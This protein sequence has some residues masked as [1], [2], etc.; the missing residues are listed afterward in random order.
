MS[1]HAP[2]GYQIPDE[3]VRVAEAAF[4]KGNMYMELH[5]K[6]GMLYTNTQFAHLFRQL[7]NRHTTRHAWPW[8][9]CSSFSKDSPTGRRPRPCAAGLTGSINSADS[10]KA[11]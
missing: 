1:M 6:L 11:L 3:T 10:P 4:P 7:T 5:A 2:L 8:C 9:W